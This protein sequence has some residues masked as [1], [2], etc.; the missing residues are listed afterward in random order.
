M[1][2]DRRNF[3]KKS[4]LLGLSGLA[5]S[6]LGND[7]L[8]H[9]E[10]ATQH[11]SDDPRFML[12]ALEYSYSDLQPYLDRQTVETHYTK[13]HQGYIDK[14]NA[15]DP[16]QFNF[17]LNDDMLCRSVDSTTP[18]NFRNNLGGYYNHNLYWMLMK[19][20]LKGLPNDPP[21]GIFS[22]ALKSSFGSIDNFK[23][24]FTDKALKVFGSGWCWL[25]EK[26]LKLKIVTTPNQDN[27]LM[28]VWPDQGPILMALDVWEHAY[29]LKYQNR[30][31]EYINNWWNLV[32]WEMTARRFLNK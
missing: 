27:P 15:M 21:P 14:L 3:L 13:H 18:E 22:E 16:N 2:D 10:Q 4:A 20:N 6:L 31:V 23:K 32:H 19:P 8:N 17:K 11:F 12:P 30:R 9:M 5:G 29:Y 26:D 24:E 25:I 28:K 1:N 7:G